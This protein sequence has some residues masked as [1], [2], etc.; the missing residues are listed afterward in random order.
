MVCSIE[1]RFFSASFPFYRWAE[2]CHSAD[3][4]VHQRLW[5]DAPPFIC[6]VHPNA[7]HE[8][9]A[10]PLHRRRLALVCLFTLPRRTR[11]LVYNCFAIISL[12]KKNIFGF[13]FIA[14][15]FI[16][17]RKEKKRFDFAKTGRVAPQGTLSNWMIQPRQKERREKGGNWEEIWKRYNHETIG[18]QIGCVS[19]SF[20]AASKR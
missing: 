19:N 5:Y 17:R 16:F 9:P 13:F 6:A 14:L 4:C 8:H 15:R 18:H 10:R 3:H 2:W 12:R 20:S 11:A 1:L 7:R